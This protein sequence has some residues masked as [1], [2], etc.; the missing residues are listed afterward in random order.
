MSLKLP[1]LPEGRTIEYVPE[2]N[3]FMAEA[4]RVRN[5]FS[6]D[7]L[8]PTG[9]VVVFEG[10]IIGAAANKSALKNKRLRDFHKDKFCVRRFFKIPTGQKYWLCPG[11]ASFRHHGES[12]AVRDAVKKN[13]SIAGADLYL[14]GHWWCCKPCWDSMIKAGIKNVF[15]VQNADQLFSRK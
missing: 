1:Y 5:E 12:R 3:P 6:T 9:A 2:E 14:Y 15:L 10:R 13:G 4:K 8:F 11:C 7:Q